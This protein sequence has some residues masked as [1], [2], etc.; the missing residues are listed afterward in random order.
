LPIT[1]RQIKFAQAIIHATPPDPPQQNK[2][3]A[4]IQPKPT[5]RSCQIYAIVL[6]GSNLSLTV[7]P[8]VD[9]ILL[10]AGKLGRSL[11]ATKVF[12]ARCKRVARWRSCNYRAAS[13]GAATIAIPS[14]FL[15]RPNRICNPSSCGGDEYMNDSVHELMH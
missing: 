5:S 15:L 2:P 13:L 1:I 14:H 10:D 8:Y 3:T 6:S 7:A 9:K 12:E 4:P 11:S